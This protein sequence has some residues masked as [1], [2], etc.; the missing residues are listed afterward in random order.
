MKIR[1]VLYLSRFCA[2]EELNRRG[3]GT[4]S[5]GKRVIIPDVSTEISGAVQNFTDYP[6]LFSLKGLKTDINKKKAVARFYLIV[7]LLRLVNDITPPPSFL[8]LPAIC[9]ILLKPYEAGI[10]S[11]H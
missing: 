4:N 6:V 9:P 11:G 8:F 5:D 7:L 10:Q 2:I 3:K 1:A